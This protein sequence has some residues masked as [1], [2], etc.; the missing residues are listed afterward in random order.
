MAHRL[1][2]VRDC[3]EIIVLDRGR[4]AERGTHEEL[5]ARAGIYSGL[6]ADDPEADG[7][8]GG[9]GSVTQPSQWV[10]GNKTLP[11]DANTPAATILS[12]SLAVFAAHKKRSAV[13]GSIL[14]LP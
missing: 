13:N 2:T 14:L 5:I 10:A 7:S 1:S 8:R 6:L 3:D 11:L 9:A 4:V 12:G